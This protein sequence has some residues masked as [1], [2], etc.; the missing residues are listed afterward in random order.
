MS[1]SLYGIFG[2]LRPTWVYFVLFN[3]LVLVSV[4]LGAR[5][6]VKLFFPNQEVSLARRAAWTYDELRRMSR[7][8]L[9]SV[10]RRTINNRPEYIVCR[11][12]EV[13]ATS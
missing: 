12:Q 7:P 10:Q 5:S 2:R 6:A 11:S 9:P 13:A 4:E 8:S 3:L 1:S